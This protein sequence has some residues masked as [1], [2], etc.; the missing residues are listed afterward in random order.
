MK[1]VGIITAMT[2]ELEAVKKIMEPEKERKAINGID[3]LIGKICGV[4]CV[5]TICGAGKVN[6]ARTT[7][8]LIDKFDIEYIIN[9]GVAGALGY[10]LKV[11]DVVIGKKI[12]QH[13][14]DITAFGHSKGYVPG[15]GNEIKSDGNLV[16]KFETAID[17][18]ESRTYNVIT[19]IVATGDIFV[20][21]VAMKDKIAS[22][23]R[24][25]CVE[26]EGAAIAQICKLGDVPFI[27]IRS[28]SDSPNGHN[29]LDYNEYLK[30][31]SK[32]SANIL[33]EYFEKE[34]E[35]LQ[36]QES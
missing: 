19:G 27:V 8:I 20:T 15:V 7:Q 35:K 28:I 14:F 18:L 30:L 17:D 4:D 32:R 33:K 22:K 9:V 2:E 31:A 29:E 23:F 36:T 21:E 13:D 12:V 6:A 24:A 10:K 3:M 11:G 5:V 25:D 16:E 26:M 1:Y 34:H